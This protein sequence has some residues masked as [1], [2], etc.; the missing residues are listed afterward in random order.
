MNVNTVV[1]PVYW[2]MIEAEEGTFHFESVKSLIDQ[3]RSHKKKLILLWFGLWKNGLSTY[4]PSWMKVDQ[5]NYPFVQKRDGG[6]IYSITPLCTQAVDKDAFAFQ[7]LMKFLKGYDLN[8]QTVIMVQIENEVGALATDFDYRASTIAKLEQ[9]IPEEVSM[10]FSTQGT[11]QECFGAEA[12]EFFMAYY[13]AKAI[14]RIAELGNQEY[15]LPF[16]VNAWL[17]KYPARPGEYP[18]GGPTAKIG[19]F[20]KKITK[21]ICAFAP[22]IYVPNFSEVCEQYLDFQ[23][24]LLVPET[25]QDLNT[26]ANLL[27]GISKY[28]IN[29]FSPFAIEDFL[30]EEQDTSRDLL[31]ALAIDASAF[32][33]TGT[34]PILSNT[35]KKLISM[36]DMLVNYRGTDKI[37][38][39]YKQRESDRGIVFKLENCE[40]KISY[41]N[42]SDN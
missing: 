13:Y 4:V 23:D 7:Q 20:W 6:R 14:D 35:Y 25:R 32:D 2:E 10:L 9:E 11:W 34:G 24:N 1:A 36:S 42:Y 3:A 40:V 26:I 18:T 8:E 21:N 19:P 30:K 37:Y 22:D 29:C 39:F 27:Y 12:K 41:Q 16:F 5:K 15:S 38:P 33:Y 31:T 28:N 17:E